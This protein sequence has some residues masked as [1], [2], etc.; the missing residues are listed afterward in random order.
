MEYLHE[1]SPTTV[2]DETR[3]RE[4]VRSLLEQ[5]RS[6]GPLR[7]VLILPP[8]MTR[9]HSWAGFLT[10][11]LFEQLHREAEIAILPALGTHLPM[12]ADELA[13]M[14]PGVPTSVFHPHDW[15]NGVRHVGDVPAA[16]VH[17]IS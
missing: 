15:R 11:E 17:D 7:R 14:F 4:H 6:R 13:H 9:L 12:S 8:D 1:G 5:L 10:C 16:F 3:A 2:I